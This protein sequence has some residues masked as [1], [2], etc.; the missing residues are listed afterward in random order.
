MA[1]RDHRAFVRALEGHRLPALICDRD[2]FDRN[3]TALGRRA[4][5]RPI[6]VASKSVRCV[7]L[8]ERVLAAR[9]FRG[10]L[11]FSVLEA[12]RLSEHGIDD[13]VVAYPSVEASELEAAAVRIHEGSKIVLMVD[14]VAQLAAIEA[15]ATGAGVEIPLCIDID[16]SLPIA[17]LWFGVRRSPLRTPAQAVGLAREI[18][19]RRGMRLVGLMGY[20]AQIAGLADR[21]G[22]GASA[23]QRAQAMA[24][25]GLKALSRRELRERRGAIVEAVRQEADLDFVNGG[26]TGSLES[27]ASDPSVTEVTAGSGLYAPQLF[28]DYEGFSHRPALAFALPVTRRPAPGIYTLHGGGYIASGA[29]GADRLPRPWRPVGATLLEAEGAGEVQTPIAY[30][31]ILEVGQPVLFR[32]PKAGE[33]CERFRDILVV[34]GDPMQVIESVPTYRGMGWCFL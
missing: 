8:L 12:V 21:P 5:A 22:R 33:V 32:H 10:V 19:R 2:A 23:A 20:E 1:P 15:A 16:L 13:L 34:G 26:G 9:G 14:D 31:G 24:I 17:G 4:G 28:D 27:T 3:V 25:R 29:A 6:R 7:A 18:G 11:C 30:L